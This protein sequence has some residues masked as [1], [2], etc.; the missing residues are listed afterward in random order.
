[1][2]NS[3]AQR[4]QRGVSLIEMMVGVVVGLF[5]IGGALALFATSAVGSR[6]TVADARVQQDLRNIADLV[7]RDLRRAGYW[8]NSQAGTKAVSASSTVTTPNPYSTI[9]RTESSTEGAFSYAFSRDTTEDN[10]KGDNESFGFSV[11][12]AGELQMQTSNGTVSTLNDVGYT[13]V[14]A[15]S[16]TDNSPAAI[17][18]GYRCE[19]VK[20]I[21]S[22]ETPY[23]F[24]RRY[25][26]SITG[27]SALDSN[28]VRTLKTTVRVRNDRVEGNC[29]S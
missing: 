1:M 21:G 28:V 27:Q 5:I 13:K 10:A 3:P 15:F 6:R 8:G 12:A 26:I 17:W 2:L 11:T 14:T 23:V 18:L 22:P 16:V 9:D 7:A 20:P 24:V 4:R 19:T 29:D 25:D